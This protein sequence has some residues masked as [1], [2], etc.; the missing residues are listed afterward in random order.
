MTKVWKEASI[1]FRLC[2]ICDATGR[3]DRLAVHAE[4]MRER[5]EGRP[6][7]PRTRASTLIWFA[8]AGRA[9]GDERTAARA[10]QQGTRSH[11]TTNSEV[12][13]RRRQAYATV[14]R[15]S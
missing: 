15:R 12:I 6:Y 13:W 11:G 2:E 4:D 3:F 8:V 1:L 10:F 14:N 9:A 5:S 7:L